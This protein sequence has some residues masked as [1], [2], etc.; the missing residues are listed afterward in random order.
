MKKICVLLAIPAYMLLL[1]GFTCTHSS[2]GTKVGQAAFWKKSDPGTTH[3][4]Y[5][6]NVEKGILPF[7]PDSL[8]TP[9]SDITQ[10]QGLS[11][12]LQPGRY[13]IIAKDKEGNVLCKGALS[14]KKTS[15]SQ[16]TKTSWEN[17]KCIVEVVYD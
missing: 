2:Y 4:L 7:L 12:L 8:T 6:D 10:K 1:A 14:L 17:D 16:E 15:D 3:Y 5:I 9:G 13:D 11:L